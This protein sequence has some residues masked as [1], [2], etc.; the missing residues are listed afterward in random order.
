MARVVASAMTEPHLGCHVDATR[1]LLADPVQ[2][3]PN[4]VE[5][6]IRVVAAALALEL[7]GSY[8]DAAA[9][10]RGQTS[11]LAARGTP[12]ASGWLALAEARAELAIGRPEM[13]RRAAD[14]ATVGF[15]D[16]NHPSGVRW[17][18]GAALLAAALAGDSSACR[19]LSATFDAL[20]PG[21]RFLEGDPLRAR[22]WAA[23]A[24]GD[25]TVA[26]RLLRESID[27]SAERGAIALE[28]IALHDSFRLLRSPVRARLAML[29]ARSSAPAVVLRAEHVRS[30]ASRD[31]TGL[32]RLVE[33]FEGQG[34]WLIAAEVAADAA[35]IASA[36]GLRSL[37]R[38]ATGHRTRLTERC[39]EPW[40]P[41]LADHGPS[42]LTAREH[43]V[44]S[45]ATSGA[46]SRAIAEQLGLSRRTVDNLLQRVYVK[47]GVHGRAELTLRLVGQETGTCSPGTVPACIPHSSRSIAPHGVAHEPTRVDR[48]T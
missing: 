46:T 5:P 27:G 33:L 9:L 26:S 30:V 29:A 42:R 45:L 17:A 7:A 44:A 37:A 34:A 31:A 18:V 36:E 21:V 6:A 41:S 32:L 19:E 3:A 25:S 22:A 12:I 20:R 24:M 15:T 28:A 40:T 16:A 38:T 8:T 47:L 14:E 4:S 1:L 35:A 23:W 11:Q 39:G 10:V 13:A 48:R 43:D 2:L